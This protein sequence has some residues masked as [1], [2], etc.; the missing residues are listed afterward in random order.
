MLNKNV[1]GHVARMRDSRCDVSI[2]VGGFQ[3]D[4]RVDRVVKGV[5]HIMR[6]ARMILVLL[7]QFE[8]N[9]ACPHVK[10]LTRVA[11]DRCACEH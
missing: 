1:R 8:R 6:G 4:R 11:R 2:F 5:N 10:S 7:E 9:S 3:S